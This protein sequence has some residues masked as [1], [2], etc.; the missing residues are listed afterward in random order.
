MAWKIVWDD[1]ALDLMRKYS[2]KAVAVALRCCESSVARKRRSLGL[3]TVTR[4]HWTPE[5]EADLHRLSDDQ[6]VSKYNLPSG[7]EAVATH[8]RALG[9]MRRPRVKWREEWLAQLGSVSDDELAARLCLHK[10]TVAAK[11]RSLGIKARIV[12]PKRRKFCVQS[13][14]KAL[15]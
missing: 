11:R 6:M 9:I 12:M 8:R 14:K 1:H 4:I 5:M 3:P 7:A 15:Q 13:S 2:D 10:H